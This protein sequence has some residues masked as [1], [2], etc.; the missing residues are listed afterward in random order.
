MR[1]LV[2]G[3]RHVHAAR[4]ASPDPGAPLASYQ[5][6]RLF[7]SQRWC[8]PWRGNLAGTTHHVSATVRPGGGTRSQATR[9]VGKWRLHKLIAGVPPAQPPQ[10]HPK[11]PG[12]PQKPPRVFIS[13]ASEDKTRFAMP[14]A[15]LLIANG[16]DQ[17]IDLWEVRGGDSLPEMIL[18]QGLGRSDDVIIGLSKVSVQ[19]FGYGRRWTSQ[20]SHA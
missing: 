14:L 15:G 20:Q 4:I 6:P 3:S 16:I 10:Y 5:G 18:N 13:Q 9:P 19:S 1:F 8:R 7:S 2:A 17:W 11:M 12:S